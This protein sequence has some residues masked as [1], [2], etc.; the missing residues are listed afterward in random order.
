MLKGASVETPE[1][2]GI[3]RG[4]DTDGR[5]EVILYRTAHCVYYHEHDLRIIPCTRDSMVVILDHET[6]RFHFTTEGLRSFAYGRELWFPIDNEK[7]VFRCIEEVLQ[8]AGFCNHV[9]HVERIREGNT[10]TDLK[11]TYSIED[12]EKRVHG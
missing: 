11:V 9:V 10:F 7:G 4:K 2:R 12:M 3:V 5:I 1:G 8:D 6:D